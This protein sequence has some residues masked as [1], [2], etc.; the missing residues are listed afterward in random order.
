NYNPKASSFERNAGCDEF[1]KKTN[2]KYAQDKWTLENMKFSK[3]NPCGNNHPTLKP[4]KLIYQIAKLLKMPVNQK[5]LFPFAGS[6]SEIIGFLKAG[7][8]D[9][10]GCEINQEYIDI[11][12]SRIKY[13]QFV[14]FNLEYKQTEFEKIQKDIQPE[15]F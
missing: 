4:I 14:N 5:V 13:W 15:L 11:A 7:F 6:G 8:T 3:S 10:H 12:N 2:N 1:E 9:I